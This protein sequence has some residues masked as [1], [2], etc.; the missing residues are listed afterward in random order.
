MNAYYAAYRVPDNTIEVWLDQIVEF[1]FMFDMIFCFFQE[2][3]DEETFVTIDCPLTIMKHY[4]KKNFIYDFL[5]WMPIEIII[6]FA[7]GGHHS[8]NFHIHLLRI[9]KMLRIPR[10][11]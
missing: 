11:A 8:E 2:Y 4:L 5:A 9:L 1:F 10:L 7:N 6:E 3:V